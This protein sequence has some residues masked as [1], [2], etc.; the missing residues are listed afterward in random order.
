MQ[1]LVSLCLN[2]CTFTAIRVGNDEN[3]NT[4]E[5]SMLNDKAP[6]IQLR[7]IEFFSGIGGMHYALKNLVLERKDIKHEIVAAYDFSTTANDVYRYNHT[8]S[9]VSS[10]LT[11]TDHKIKVCSNM[12]IVDPA[13]TDPFTT[14]YSNTHAKID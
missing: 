7:V 12:H 14:A 3:E 9:T 10:F 5:E 8:G 13:I 2:L 1:Y 6:Q 11:T 4:M